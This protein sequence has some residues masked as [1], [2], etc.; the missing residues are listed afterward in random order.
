LTLPKLLGT[1]PFC[2]LHY[3]RSTHSVSACAASP[4]T[5][6]ATAVRQRPRHQADA[7]TNHT[8][9]AVTARTAA[10]N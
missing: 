1:I 8:A 3:L 7:E 10:D 6:V 9:P 4:A 5:A 2:H